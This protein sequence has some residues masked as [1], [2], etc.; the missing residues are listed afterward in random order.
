VITFG[1]FLEN[2]F[3]ELDDKGKAKY[4]PDEVFLTKQE[5]KKK[6]LPLKMALR[7]LLGGG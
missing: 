3:N 6:S 7:Q 5:R 1:V 2:R 4:N